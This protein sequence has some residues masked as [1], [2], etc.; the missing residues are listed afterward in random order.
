MFLIWI[1]LEVY[2]LS[3]YYPKDRFP[4]YPDFRALV[5]AVGKRGEKTF[6]KYILGKDEIR[7]LSYKQFS[8]NIIR[9][10]TALYALGLKGKRIA[11]VSEARAEWF[12]AYL[13]TLCA[14]SVI[15]PI[16]KELMP[17]QIINFASLAECDAVFISPACKEKLGTLLDEANVKYIIEMTEEGYSPYKGGYE[18]YRDNKVFNFYDLVAYGRHLMDAGFLGVFDITY[19]VDAMCALIFTS[20]TTGT[21]KGVMLSQR[22]LLT[23]AWC[24]ANT[25]PFTANDVF[26]SVLPMHHTYETTI[27]I[28]ILI[29][30]ATVCINNSIKYVMRNL[31]RFQPT[32]LVLVPLFVQTIFKRISEEI[33][34]KGKENT[35]NKAVKLTKGLRKIKL[36]LRR[37]VFSEVISALGGKIKN[38][39]CGGAALDEE[40]VR[41]FEEFGVNL[42]QG[43]GITECSPLVSVNPYTK[44]KYA[45]IG[46]PI[47]CCD[48]KILK[49][50]CGREVYAETREHGE[51]IVK[52][53]NVMLGYFKNAEATNDSFTSDGYFRT[54]DIGYFDDDG[55]L[56]ITGR[57]K[58]LII[59]SNG[60]NVYPE[61][62]EEYLLRLDSIKECAVI[63]RNNELDEPV[64][65]AIIVPDD[66]VLAMDDA[67]I[68]TKIKEDVLSVNDKLPSFK[69][70]R[71]I[72]IR[73]TDFEKTSSQKIKRH[74]L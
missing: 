4:S 19:D 51:I 13:G 62:I 33:R 8:D 71:N 18:N 64:I 34:K 63:A 69:Q 3:K 22:N 23:C 7:E 10:A 24:C 27:Q 41:R 11:I 70:I 26:L 46:L 49:D 39:I 5:T 21:S 57:K 60:K 53:D 61:E 66:S 44:I 52:G 16:D 67:G 43:Y 25:T 55:Y 42:Y 17:E 59:L 72:E 50:V 32:G 36:D 15:V 12:Q 35:F 47:K 2:D 48:V 1:N 56:Y 9:L 73:K 68:Q 29:V 30:G 65:T 28:A 54:G 31:K 38:I 40:L 14:S 58:N 45:S 74:V 6:Y 37:P 20:G